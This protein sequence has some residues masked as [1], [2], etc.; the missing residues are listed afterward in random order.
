MNL[1]LKPDA[2]YWIKAH[3]EPDKWQPAQP[4]HWVLNEQGEREY[5]GHSFVT[6]GYEWEMTAAEVGPE[7]EVPQ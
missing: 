3:D 7:I 1:K 6:I 4:Y 2:Y 5:T